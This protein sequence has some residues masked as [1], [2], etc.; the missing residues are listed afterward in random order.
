MKDHQTA[1]PKADILVVDDT[2]ISLRF[3]TRMLTQKGYN[4]KP[5]LNGRRALQ[6]VRTEH[7]DLILLDIVMPDMSG[8]EVCGE[9]K[10]DEQTRDIPVIFISSLDEVVDK[11]KAFSV[12]A[13]DYIT[14]PFQSEEVL[15]RV[16]THLAL[17][18]LQKHLEEKNAQLRKEIN[19][20]KQAEKALRQT[21]KELRQAKE[22]AEAASQAKSAFLASMSHELRTPLNAILGFSQ[23]MIRSQNLPVEHQENLFIITHSGEHLLNLINDVLDMSKIEA[24]RIALHKQNFDLYRMLDELEDMFRFQAEEK[25]LELIFECIPDVPRYVQTDEV[26]LRQVLINLLNNAVK[27]TSEGGVSLRAKSKVGDGNSEA[28]DRGQPTTDNRQQTILFEVE[29]TGPGIAAEELDDMFEAFVQTKVGRE[30]QEG[31]GLGLPISQKFVQLMGGEMNVSSEVGRGSVFR[32]DIRVS[33]VDAGDIRTCLPERRI[34]AL[35]ADQPCYRIL[36]VDNK[37]SN[38]QLLV[39]LLS[40]LGFKLREACDGQEAIEIWKSWE[41]HLIWM[42]MRMPVMDGYEAAK[43]IK[44]TI[45]G[46]ATAII[47]LTAST[48]EEERKVVLSTGCDD[49]LRKPFREAEIF[50]MM[51]K[52]LGIRYV[53]DEDRPPASPQSENGMETKRI[54]AALAAVPS[55]LTAKLEHA[56][57]RANMDMVCGIIEEIRSHDDALGGVLAS[58]ADEFEYTKILR[59]IQEAKGD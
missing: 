20:R 53:Y 3:L 38:R 59:L 55:D 23:L 30:S 47:A 39:K 51:K 10:A 42:D 46:Q 54:P 25:E 1:R 41:P 45:R 5:V 57:I 26:R 18:N 35:E 12:G 58:M 14:K 21:Q 24:G 52:H 16:E 7:F 43:R 50:D 15:A 56:T 13:I 49:F 29:D 36:I 44:A 31:T 19:E 48:F 9:L 28:A 17:R 34:I 37:Q 6:S 22:A 11:V 2:R 33:V 32:F 27:F 4:V 40:P 8:Y